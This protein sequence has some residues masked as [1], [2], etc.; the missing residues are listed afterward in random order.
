VILEEQLPGACAQAGR[1]NRRGARC[2]GFNGL[3]TSA[4]SVA[5]SA[6]VIADSVRDV[7]NATPASGS[8]GEAVNAAASA[9]DPWQ[10]PLPGPYPPGSAGKLI[11]DQLDARI[12]TRLATSSY[13]APPTTNAIAIANR[14]ISNASPT[15][16]SVGDKINSAASA[17]DPWSTVLPSAT[18]PPGTAGDIIG[19]NIDAKISDTLQSAT[20][21]PPPTTVEISEAVRDVDNTAP[22]S[23]SLGAAINEGS[24]P[25][26]NLVPGSYAPGTAG[27]VLGDNLNA[28]VSSRSTYAGTDTPGTTTLLT[29]VPGP[30]TTT[31]GKVD[32]NDKTGF[33]L[34]PAYDAAKTAA[35]PGD[36]MSLTPAERTTLS[37]AIWQ[38]LT[39][40]MTLVGSMGKLIVDNLNATVSS[41]LPT[42]S[43]VA[44]DNAGIASIKAKTDTIRQTPVSV[45][46]V[47]TAAQNAAATRDVSNTSPPA[48][49]LG[50]DVKAGAV[51]GVTRGQ[52]RFP[53][54]ILLELPGTFLAPSS[55]L[56]FPAVFRPPIL[57]STLGR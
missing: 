14:D 1:K 28:T 4:Y 6:A 43:Y 41:R 47:P 9:G 54:L 49:S 12:S 15:P 29:R 52:C 25:L 13:T 27:K 18:Y 19:T 38:A 23:N 55:M 46:D 16:G 57:P 51:A 17:G 42:S 56:L 48:G 26:L 21:V 10:T 50:A 37:A 3:A 34:T 5:P 11:S 31:G 2:F 30:I 7:S 39:S 44:P 33:S 8:L 32:V 45:S 24:D 22:A 40:A 20:Y 36:P 35:Q 53:R